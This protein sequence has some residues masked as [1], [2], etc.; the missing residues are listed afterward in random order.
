MYGLL[1]VKVVKNSLIPYIEEV[2]KEIDVKE[3]TIVITPMEGL[4]S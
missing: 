1:K 4:L 3:K 2:V